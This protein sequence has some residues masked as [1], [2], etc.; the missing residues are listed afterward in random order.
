MV[1]ED[2]DDCSPI[3]GG[4]IGH[5]Q[6]DMLIVIQDGDIN[7]IVGR[8]HGVLFPAEWRSSMPP[9]LVKSAI[10]STAIPT[11]SRL[12]G[13]EAAER[14]RNRHGV[15]LHWYVTG[16]ANADQRGVRDLG[17]E[18]L[19]VLNQLESVVFAPDQ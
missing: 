3:E 9:N 2:R 1:V 19:G 6:R 7:E 5:L 17:G 16:A 18:T 12:P 13:K 11:R 15:V 10:G 4:P 14:T 8:N